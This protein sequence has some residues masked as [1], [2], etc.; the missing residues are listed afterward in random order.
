[1]IKLLLR[2]PFLQI[3]GGFTPKVKSVY[4]RLR[5]VPIKRIGKVKVEQDIL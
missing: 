1:L 3:S 2:P 4:E 5:K